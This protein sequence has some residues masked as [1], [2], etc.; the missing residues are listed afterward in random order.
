MCT[1]T[2]S[3]SFILLCVHA[4]R[5][6]STANAMSVITAARNDTIDARSMKVM[7]VEKDRRNAAKAAMAARHSFSIPP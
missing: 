5:A 4:N 3:K 1:G 6:M 7:C 2:P